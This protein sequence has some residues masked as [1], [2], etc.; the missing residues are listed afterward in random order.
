MPVLIA[1][2]AQIL[3]RQKSVLSIWQRLQIWQCKP[4]GLTRA[5]TQKDHNISMVGAV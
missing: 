5:L 1:T 3:N 4:P 2:A